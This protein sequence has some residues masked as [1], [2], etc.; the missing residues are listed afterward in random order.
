MPTFSI[1]S[2]GLL[3]KTAVYYNGE[4]LGGVKEVFLNLDED[5][6][7]DGIIQYEGIDKKI[8]TKQ[9]FNEYLEA[10]KT[11]EPSF[12]DDEAEDLQLFTVESDGNIENTTVFYNKEQLEGIVNIFLH[13]KAVQNKNGIRSLFSTKKAIPEHVEFRTEITFRNEDDTLETE[14]IF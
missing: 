10:I 7:F 4:Q 2:N 13:I 6:T 8:Y 9:I 14:G 3:E 1:E 5:G 11:V 12:T